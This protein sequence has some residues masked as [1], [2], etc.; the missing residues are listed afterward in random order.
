MAAVT[1]W[2]ITLSSL[3]AGIT[4]ETLGAA[5]V[6]AGAAVASR[7]MVSGSISTKSSKLSLEAG[8]L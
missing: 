6:G 5:D 8:S 4:I 2:R 1:H 7:R 3:Y